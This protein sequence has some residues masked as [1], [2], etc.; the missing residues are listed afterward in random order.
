MQPKPPQLQAWLLKSCL[1]VSPSHR[2]D[3]ALG[4]SSAGSQGSSRPKLALGF[5]VFRQHHWFYLHVLE[6]PQLELGAAPVS[7]NT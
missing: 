3:N 4:N 2:R 6:L 7:S 5:A 1:R